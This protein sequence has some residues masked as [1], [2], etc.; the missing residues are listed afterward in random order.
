MLKA[1]RLPLQKKPLK[2]ESPK[3]YSKRVRLDPKTKQPVHYDPKPRVVVLNVATGEYGL[4]WIGYDGT[5]KTVIYQRPDR[6]DAIVS[7][8]VSSGGSRELSYAYL[9]KVQNLHSSGQ[10]LAGFAVQNSSSDIAT[11]VANS[12]VHVGQMSP[13]SAMKEGNWVRFGLLKPAVVPG[14]SIQFELTSS[15]PPGVVECR[16]HG[17]RLGTKGVGEGMPQEL[18]NVLLGYEAWPNGFTIGPID[19]LK[20]LST[21]QRADYVRGLLPQLEKL[22]WIVSDLVPWYAQNL[23]GGDFRRVGERVRQDLKAGK[24]TSEVASLLEFTSH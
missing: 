8:S 5:E 7:V 6:I 19:R 18:V 12:A 17:G 20:T 21:A 1:V 3:A 4:R 11:A 22:G 16:V 14:C 13:N 2:L 15:A 10:H 23:K 9:Y 24:I